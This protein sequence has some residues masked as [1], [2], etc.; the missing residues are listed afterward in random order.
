MECF[1]VTVYY[2]K[3]LIFEWNNDYDI[4]P[5]FIQNSVSIHF[6]VY[7]IQIFLRF[8]F[9]HLNGIMIMIFLRMLEIDYG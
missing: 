2:G 8:Y 6:V 9:I 1:Y 3:L 5:S 7:F 4:G